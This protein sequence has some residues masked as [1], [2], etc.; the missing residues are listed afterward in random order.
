MQH[1]GLKFE[2]IDLTLKGVFL[3]DTCEICLVS[4]TVCVP[5]ALGLEG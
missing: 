2:E 1:S 3:E 5:V 4:L